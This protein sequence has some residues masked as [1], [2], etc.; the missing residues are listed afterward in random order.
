MNLDPTDEQ[1]M[2]R[3]TIERFARDHAGAGADAVLSGLAGLG[4]LALPVPEMAGG[5]GGQG[6]DLMVMMQ[7][8]GNSLLPGPLAG[9][10]AALD[11]LGHHGSEEQQARWLVPAMEG[12][13]RLVFA[14]LDS[15][16]LDAS[17]LTASAPLV[18]GADR[19]DAVVFASGQGAV[20]VACDAP[21]V[22]ITPLAMADGS[23]GARVCLTDVQADPIKVAPD[24]L[25]TSVLR[26]AAAA[27]AQIL[28]IMDRLLADTLDY[29]KTRQQFGAPIG[30]F[31]TI[32]HRMAR[33]FVATEMCRSLVMAAADRSGSPH[34][35]HRRVRAALSMTSEQGL[36]L[37][38]ECVQFHGGMGIT[39]ELMVSKGHRQ[40]L[41]LTRLFAAAGITQ[42]FDQATSP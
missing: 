6:H 13:A 37:A 5:L 10:L 14:W 34:D 22:Q 38:H 12:K 7:T 11:L 23:M 2:L 30:S 31:Q 40:L 28:G 35:W 32:Q 33:L 24:A 16:R 15:P 27:S 39:A 8:V 1:A 17:G 36:H 9:T 3:D 25:A 41:V 20:I 42:M 29:V 21:G 18:P 26:A 4:L 19:A